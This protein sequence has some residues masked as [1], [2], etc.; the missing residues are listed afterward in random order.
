MSKIRVR[1]QTGK[2]TAWKAECLTCGDHLNPQ[3]NNQAHQWATT[4]ARQFPDHHQKFEAGGDPDLQVGEEP[5]RRSV[6]Q[7]VKHMIRFSY[8][9]WERQF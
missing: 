8:G 2:R 6:L 9:L 7:I 5:T 4:H 3:N 1:Q